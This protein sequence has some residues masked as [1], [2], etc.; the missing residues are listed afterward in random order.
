MFMVVKRWVA[1]LYLLSNE[2][3]GRDFVQILLH[4]NSGRVAHRRKIVLT[5]GSSRWVVVNTLAV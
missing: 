1:A 4:C 5:E 3:V 2:M